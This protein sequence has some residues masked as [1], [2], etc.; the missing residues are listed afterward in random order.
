MRRRSRIKVENTFDRSLFFF[1]SFSS[2]SSRIGNNTAAAAS[3]ELHCNCAERERA[4]ERVRVSS[5]FEVAVA[6][7]G[8]KGAPLPLSLLRTP[9]LIQNEQSRRSLSLSV[10]RPILLTPAAPGNKGAQVLLPPTASQSIRRTNNHG[11]HAKVQKYT[12][13]RAR[14]S[15]WPNPSST[16]RRV[17]GG[18]A[19]LCR[20]SCANVTPV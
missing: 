16:S 1:R 20:G 12:L 17:T 13:H 10:L 15:H 3:V 19:L 2:S 4:S 18:G 6:A 7:G 11:L 8:K 9:Q 14:Q 5:S